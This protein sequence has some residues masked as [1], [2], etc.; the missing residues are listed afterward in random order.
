[1]TRLTGWLTKSFGKKLKK[2]HAWNA[3]VI[4]LLTISGILLFIPQVRELGQGRVLIKQLHIGLGILSVILLVMY[5]P[6]L[7]KHWKQLKQRI[8]QRTNLVVVLGLLLGWSLSGLVLW[9]FKYLPSTW[10]NTALIIHDA[11]TWLG[12]PY[13]IYH[14]VSRSRWVKQ[15]KKQEKM[16]KVDEQVQIIET[17]TEPPSTPS[18]II[19]ALKRTNIS[20]AAFLQLAAGFILVL[21]VGP[22][23]YRWLKQT[24]DSGG[25]E[26][27]RLAAS[28]E[29]QFDP[30]P[31]PL[32]DS[33]PPIGGGAIGN[34]RVYTVTD[35][36]SFTTDNW[37]FTIG[38]LVENEKTYTWKQF[39]EL[40]RKVQVCDFHC[41]TGWSVYHVT[42]EGIPLS[43][44]LDMAK[45]QSKAR[46]VKLYSGDGVYTDTGSTPIR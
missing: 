18:T 22:Y 40:K 12:V 26:L 23:F 1:M 11:F 36:P 31:T 46:Y 19:A 27:N 15:A 9:Q 44:F 24:T 3:W 14:S 33:M 6:L 35:I 32:S 16:E 42:Y 41:V 2:L 39:L 7:R 45:V 17:S 29:N 38:G 21:G 8:N 37:S 20:R 5:I 43:Q 4:V 25:A 30:L 34:F 28:D 13:A 10:S